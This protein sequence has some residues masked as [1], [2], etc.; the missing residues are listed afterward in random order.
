[1]RHQRGAAL[2]VVMTFLAISTLIAVSSMQTSLVNERMAGNYRLTTLAQMAAE[3]GGSEELAQGI[4]HDVDTTC[5]VLAENARNGGDAVSWEDG[6]DLGDDFPIPL[7]YQKAACQ[8][9]DSDALLIMGVA[10]HEQPITSNALI[11]VGIEQ[12]EPDLPLSDYRGTVTAAGAATIPTL[13]DG[14]AS[15]IENGLH[16][17]QGMH[18]VPDPRDLA[19]DASSTGYIADIQRRASDGDPQVHSSCDADTPL[20]A[21]TTHVFCLGDFTGNITAHL[22]DV[23]VVATGSF[24][25]IKHNGKEGF[26]GI[27]SDVTTSLVA[28]DAIRIKGFGNRTITGFLWS[29]GSL[30]ISGRSNIVGGVVSNGSVQFDGKTVVTGG[31][32]EGR[33]ESA[34]LFWEPI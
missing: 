8:H 10:N 22:D 13:N 27:D 1:M 20:P 30:H 4:D 15:Y 16:A 11:I 12:L 23:T 14:N 2:I 21:D 32:Q 7:G 24:G 31:S 5:G 9:R 28:G 29:A 26:L 25:Y 34:D 3:M 19:G 18:N 17:N 33:G 6:A